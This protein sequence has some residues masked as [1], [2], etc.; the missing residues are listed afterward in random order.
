MSFPTI[1]VTL[2]IT[3]EVEWQGSTEPKHADMLRSPSPLLP[4]RATPL[5][6]TFYMTT[7]ELTLQ[8]PF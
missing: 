4:E 6:L 8:M 5:L 1:C 3:E 7:N 2:R